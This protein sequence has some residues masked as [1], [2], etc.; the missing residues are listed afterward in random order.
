MTAATTE[1]LHPAARGLDLTDRA[2]LDH[3]LS[4]QIAALNAISP[5]LDAIAEASAFAATVR[6]GGR[7]VYA[8]AGSSALMAV[9][10]GLELHGT[11]GI[12]PDRIRLHGGRVAA[13][14]AYA[15]R[16]RR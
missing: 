13:G 3:I 9:A 14:R 12:A 7:L 15:G 2:I 1:R 8:G 4:T 11:F 6:G 16:Y 5:A 10:D